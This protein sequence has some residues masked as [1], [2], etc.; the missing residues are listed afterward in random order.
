MTR[1]VPNEQAVTLCTAIIESTADL[2]DNSGCTIRVDGG[3]CI[4]QFT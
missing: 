3:S 2:K 1:I 4:F